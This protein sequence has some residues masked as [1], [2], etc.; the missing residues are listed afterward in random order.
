M[1]HR[2]F[3]LFILPSLLAMT[4]FIALPLVSVAIQSLYV[5]HPQVLVTV[6]ACDPFGCKTDTRVDT[7]AMAQLNEEQPQGRFNG[8][9]TY[10]NS[11]HLAIED[12]RQ[13]WAGAPDTETALREIANLPLYKALVFTLVYTVVVSPLSLG[14][15][16]LIALAVSVLPRFTRGPVI[17]FTLLP[18]IVPPVV[19]AL[20][21]FWIIDQRGLFGSFLQWATGNPALSLKASAPLAWATLFAHG[22]WSSAP[23][24]FIVYYAALQTVPRDTLEAAMVDG[25]SRIERLRLVTLPHLRP[26]TTFLVLI[27][28]MDNFRVF[29]S[30]IGL[31]ATAHASSLSTMIFFA[32]RGDTPLFGSAAA[33]SMLTI[34]CIA[35]LLLPSLRQAW[36][37]FRVKA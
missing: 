4:L 31:S 3:A 37:S 8:L 13:I 11:A 6:E 14:L 2:V 34:L 10:L 30:I 19:G 35:V 21:L 28:I 9:G 17:Y 5:E 12:V 20:T 1:P 36:T 29:E 24:V 33:T 7:A 32:L 18:M 23:F 16:L 27:L 22:T 25:A 15:G 26:V